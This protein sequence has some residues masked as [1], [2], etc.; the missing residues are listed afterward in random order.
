MCTHA[1]LAHDAAIAEYA[2]G[3]VEWLVDGWAVVCGCGSLVCV[4][5]MRSEADVYE[6]DKED[7]E[8]QLGLAHDALAAQC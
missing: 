1:P 5:S 4:S 2:L 7:D 3:P 8:P 6:W